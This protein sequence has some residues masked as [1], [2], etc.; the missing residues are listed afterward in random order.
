MGEM[1]EKIKFIWGLVIFIVA[2]LL[3]LFAAWRYTGFGLS[4]GALRISAV[5]FHVL[6]VISLLLF[7]AQWKIFPYT[8]LHVRAWFT[9]HVWSIMFGMTIL[10]IAHFLLFARFYTISYVRFK[11]LESHIFH[12]ELNCNFELDSVKEELDSVK[13]E[14]KEIRWGIG[15]VKEE[16]EKIRWR[17]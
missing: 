17:L 6:L 5:A 11:S 9:N 13:E 8:W 16:I 10:L 4:K 2:T 12:L 1:K 3:P 15:S 14:I 7:Y